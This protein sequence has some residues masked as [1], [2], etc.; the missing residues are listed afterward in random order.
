MVS[1]RE[2]ID[3]LPGPPSALIADAVGGVT[4]HRAQRNCELVAD[5]HPRA[6]LW[7]KAHMMGVRRLVGRRSSKLLRHKLEMLLVS[8]PPLLRKRRLAVWV[9]GDCSISSS[10][11]F[12]IAPAPQ[13]LGTGTYR[14]PYRVHEHRHSWPNSPEVDES[15]FVAFGKRVEGFRAI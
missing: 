8:N 6:C 10:G 5:L 14:Q 3:R 15:A 11:N 7:G 4:V 1:R 13:D 12:G 9:L 2:W